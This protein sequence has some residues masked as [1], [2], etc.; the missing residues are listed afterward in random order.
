MLKNALWRFSRIV[1]RFQSSRWFY[2]TPVALY[3]AL[4][5]FLSSLSDTDIYVPALSI[6]HADKVLH[7][8]LYGPL[9]ILT[10]R[11]F[12]YASGTWSAMHAVFL[13]VAA[14]TAYGMTDEFHQAFIP[15]RE[16]NV[17]DLFA[18]WMGSLAG[19]WG[20]AHVEPQRRSIEDFSSPGNRV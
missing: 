14:S 2:W 16:A 6:P 11:A 17:W 15:M 7:A 13:A 9:A 4:I 19:A 10:Y 1:E 12:R 18:D 8:L 5:F 20:W 3:A